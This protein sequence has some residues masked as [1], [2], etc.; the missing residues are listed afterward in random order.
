MQKF[1]PLILF[2]P[3]FN[4]FSYTPGESHLGAKLGVTT[5]NSE[6][7]MSEIALYSTGLYFNNQSLEDSD[8]SFAYDLEGN[9]NLLSLQNGFGLDIASHFHA[10]HNVYTEFGLNVRP[11]LKR[12]GILSPYLIIG[13]CHTTLGED[14]NTVRVQTSSSDL[15]SASLGIGSSIAFNDIVSINPSFTWNRVEFPNVRLSESWMDSPFNFNFGK[16]NS[17]QLSLPINFQ[18]TE[19]FSMGL[20]YRL[21]MLSEVSSKAIGTI[22]GGALYGLEYSQEDSLHSFLLS[23]KYSF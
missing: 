3:V 17:F 5:K 7:S 1:I 12:G 16:A 10:K 6:G 21:A 2:F 8:T 23:S 22:N 19:N 4:L 20:E 11:F 18:I 14:E 9:L 13:I 15:F